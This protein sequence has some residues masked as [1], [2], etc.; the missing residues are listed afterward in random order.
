VSEAASGK[1][2]PVIVGVAPSLSS[3]VPVVVYLDADEPGGAVAHAMDLAS[4]FRRRGHPVAAVCHRSAE[5]EP[6]RKSL[7]EH[8]VDV[9]AP[10]T[11]DLTTLG[12]AR[13]VVSLAS[14]IRRYPGCV[15]LLMNGNY[16]SG[17]PAIAAGIIARAR[18]IVRA[19]LQP[20]MPPVLLRHRLAIVLKDLFVDRIVV[21][22]KE[23]RDSFVR[24]MGRSPDKIEVVHQGIDLPKFR[25]GLGRDDVRREL[26]YGATEQVVGVFSRLGGDVWRKGIAR[27]LEAAASV[28]AAC[29]EARFLVVG[30][31]GAKASLQLRARQ[32]G[33]GDRVLWAGWRSDVAALL[34]AIDVFVMPSL[35]EGSPTILLEAMAMAKPVVATTVGVVPEIIVDGENGL[36]V[37]PDQPDPLAI[38]IAALLADAGL[39]S[40]MGL[41]ARE[42]AERSLSHEAM[43]DGYLCV[44]AR[45]YE[46]ARH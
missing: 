43:I 19:D 36:V 7:A 12:R 42:T 37:E 41:K 46:R 6:V 1:L 18:L 39:R 33:L 23:N 15:L 17:G 16:R 25:P 28:G 2:A 40:R 4:G 22:A 26:G 21:N 27:F 14:V 3:E 38:A 9:Y 29:P 35:F 30:D 11:W 10:E 34:A 24:R 45:Q 5:M 13:R 31:G 32:L 8:G 20:P 44:F